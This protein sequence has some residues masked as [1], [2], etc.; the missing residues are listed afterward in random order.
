MKAVFA[1][2]PCKGAHGATFL[3]TA[4]DLL[5]LCCGNIAFKNQRSQDRSCAGQQGSCRRPW[6]SGGNDC[7]VGTAAVRLS[8]LVG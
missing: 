8:V 2:Q 7:N 6:W 4:N 1:I 3:P 5:C